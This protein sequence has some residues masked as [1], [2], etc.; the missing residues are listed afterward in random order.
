[1]HEVAH[2]LGDE[3]VVVKV[4][5]DVD[6]VA[7]VLLSVAAQCGPVPLRETA[8]RIAAHPADP[9]EAFAVLDAALA[10]RRLLVEDVESLRTSVADKELGDVFE[11]SS[12]RVYTWVEARAAVVTR[13]TAAWDE[14]YPR[15]GRLR[16]DQR[17]NAQVL[18][19]RV[20]EDPDAYTLAV[21]RSLLTRGD[22]A[23]LAWDLDA[24][25]RD[26]WAGVDAATRDLLTLLAVHGR[27][28][29]RQVL[30]RV[31]LVAGD[32]VDRAIDAHLVEVTRSGLSLADPS[33]WAALVQS[34][35]KDAHRRLADAFATVAGNS[36]PL[37]EGAAPLA[38]LEA[39]RHYAAIP[40]V[41]RAQEFAQFG[42]GVLLSM[43]RRLSV[44]GDLQR[45]SHTYDT[46]LRLDQQVRETGDTAGIGLRAR[47]YAIHY[48]AYNLDKA[49]QA[50]P[51]ETLNSYR[52]ALTFWPKNALFWSRTISACFAADHY[53][54]GLRAR[55]EAMNAV[56]AHPQRAEFVVARTAEDLLVRGMTLAAIL[57]WQ[58]HQPEN[59]TE[60]GIRQRLV[61]AMSDGWMEDRVWVRGAPHISFRMPVRVR[62][63]TNDKAWVC[64][65]LGVKGLG[66]FPEAAIAAAS[67]SLRADL[68][69]LVEDPAPSSERELQRRE[70][71]EALDLEVLRA[72]DET[73]RWV[74]H[75]AASGDSMPGRRFRDIWRRIRARFPEV[76]RPGVRCLEGQI[77]L[78]WSFGDRPGETF[79][80][81]IMPDGRVEWFYRNA[82]K[83]LVAG[84]DEEPEEDLPEVAF[85]LF[86][87]FQR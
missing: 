9:T 69:D 21:A 30:E 31:G 71:V 61:V 27:P 67:T 78:G 41:E 84:T 35:E 12:D 46:I 72:G 53:L 14:V 64:H 20:A 54:E 28:L 4:P 22:E 52:L 15:T 38:V 62:V 74:A 76:R 43:A 75:L 63:V 29:E 56:D 85:S 50:S 26:I 66:A 58:D 16:P 60:R 25:I 44:G 87:G 2:R 70:L 3:A 77:H 1:M 59:A 19:Q 82:A 68:L 51:D 83:G 65:L 49:R 86:A 7:Y 24:I 32:L 11:T 79:T 48:R 13:P 80:V 33:C 34:R 18:W 55:E 57:V 73:S 36:T 47:A 39:H 81:D 40:D 5:R 17:W 8:A 45:S 42:V 37:D 10:R 23:K 6:K